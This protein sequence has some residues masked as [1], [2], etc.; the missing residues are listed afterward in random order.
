MLLLIRQKQNEESNQENRNETHNTNKASSTAA[1]SILK[2]IADKKEIINK[3]EKVAT[4]S[5]GMKRTVS[6][7][8][9][10]NKTMSNNG[11]VPTVKPH[12]GCNGRT[13]SSATPCPPQTKRYN[14]Y[15][16]RQFSTPSYSGNSFFP[17]NNYSTQY[18]QTDNQYSYYTPPC[19][20]NY[21]GYQPPSAY[22]NYLNKRH[23]LSYRENFF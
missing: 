19:S 8:L 5:V 10:L 21:V 3:K 22:H 17:S 1:A 6:N 12:T 23:L 9:H 11:R 16:Q 13:V 18:Q 4:P 15:P 2:T 14:P 20:Y 7:A